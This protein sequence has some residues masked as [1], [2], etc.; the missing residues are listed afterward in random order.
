MRR[1]AE[2]ADLQ[3][4]L[5]N[6]MNKT[7]EKSDFIIMLQNRLDEAGREM[8]LLS[9]ENSKQI[10]GGGVPNL[11]AHFYPDKLIELQIVNESNYP[12]YDVNINFHNPDHTIALKK[13]METSSNL[14]WWMT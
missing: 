10:T 9:K 7:T 1:T 6:E 3:K 12:L 5:L 14:S 11:S 2:V 13:M 8:L 4:Q